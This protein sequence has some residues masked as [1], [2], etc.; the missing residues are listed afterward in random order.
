MAPP[1]ATNLTATTPLS[2]AEL[3]Y[4]RTSLLLSPPIR[5]DARSPTTFRPLTAELD[6]LP[7]THGSSRIVWP[8]GGECIVGIKAEVEKAVVDGQNKRVEVSVEVA[9]QR[10][11]DPLA[12][13]LTQSVLDTIAPRLGERL[14]IGERWNWKVYIDIL[15]LTPPISH[16]STLLSLGVNLALR[17]TKLPLLISAA[18]EDPLFSDDWDLAKPLYPSNT[19]SEVPAISL[20][21]ASVGENVFFDPTREEMSVADCVLVVSVDYD[22]KVIALRT[23]ESGSVGEG[24]VNRKVVARIVSQ[25]AEVGREV[26]EGLE[27]IAKAG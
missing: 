6:I 21:V 10:D 11:D 14:N 18:E 12:V 25:C 13:F 4:L 15:L 26:F 22:G 1:Q 24:G 23:L 9:G 7:S 17:C 16:P 19:P 27:A 5:P 20:L 2:P 3:S 8:D